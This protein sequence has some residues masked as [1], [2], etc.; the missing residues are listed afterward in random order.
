MVW[1][2]V[3]TRFHTHEQTSMEPATKAR[4]STSQQTPTAKGNSKWSR[5][6]A[7]SQWLRQERSQAGKTHTET[8]A[9]STVRLPRNIKFVASFH[10]RWNHQCS[11]CNKSRE[12][13]GTRWD[14]PKHQTANMFNNIGP[15][16]VRWLHAFYDDVVT[17]QRFQKI[18]RSAN[19]IAIRKPGKP[20][21]DPT[22][23]RPISLLCCCY[24]LLKLLLLTRLA[25]ICERVTPAE[26]P[27]SER[28]ATRV[29]KYSHLHRVRL[30]KK[31]K[32]GAVLI[33]LSAAYDIVWQTGLMMKL[34]KAIKCRTTIRQSPALLARETFQVFISNQV[35]RK[36]NLKNGLPQGS[37]LAPTF[38]DVYT[39]HQ[40]PPTNWIA[41]V[42]ICWWLD[43]FYT[44]E[45]FFT[46]WEYPVSW[47][48]TSERVLWLLEAAPQR[49]EDSG[50]LLSPGQQTGCQTTES[51]TSG[52][53]ACT[54]LCT[55]VPQC[56][57]W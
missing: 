55:K 20:L 57:S 17:K 51:D 43:M 8:T 38:F 12:G 28:N 14:L 30:Q 15:S 9:R 3:N 18:W 4:R 39:I 11:Q 37:A 48:R 35:I 24:K 36:R 40:W 49:K 23:Y 47:Y 19:V 21:D 2:N 1:S 46:C 29:I 13:C 6:S 50:D 7:S 45:D 44:I 10:H 32:T 56:D 41:D 53:R 33:D 27:C 42:G 34:S 26:Q 31:L 5:T 52:R 54:R 25:P 22:S 16:A